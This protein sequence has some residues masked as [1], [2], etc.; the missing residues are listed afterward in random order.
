MYVAGLGQKPSLINFISVSSYGILQYQFADFVLFSDN[1][2]DNIYQGY[3]IQ[4]DSITLFIY[5]TFALHLAMRN[6][7]AK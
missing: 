4:E 6:V 2:G 3:R 7:I 5:M 1:N